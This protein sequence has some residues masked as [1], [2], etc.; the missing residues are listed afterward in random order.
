MNDYTGLAVDITDQIALEGF[1]THYDSAPTTVTE[2]VLFAEVEGNYRAAIYSESN[3]LTLLAES[4]PVSTDADGNNGAYVSI[5]INYI[6]QPST[7]YYLGYLIQNTGSGA[8]V[9]IAD[10]AL[11]ITGGT[12]PRIIKAQSYGAFPA[13][14]SATP[15]NGPLLGG[16]L[17]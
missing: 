1:T 10:S 6:L 9:M 5:P 11:T 4:A 2:A 15:V 3:P 8:Y 7:N 17:K 13:T 14:I 16:Y 12:A